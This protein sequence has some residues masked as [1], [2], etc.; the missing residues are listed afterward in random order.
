M[1]KYRVLEPVTYVEG[2]AVIMHKR[3]AD[4]VTIDDDVAKKLGDKVQRLGQPEPDPPSDP[5]SEKTPKP[6]A[7]RE[8]S[9]SA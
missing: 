3:P 6:A 4:V 1:G 7:P 8:R 5:E 9:S 2:K